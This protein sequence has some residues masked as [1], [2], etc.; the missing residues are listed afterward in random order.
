MTADIPDPAM[1]L[2]SGPLLSARLD[3]RLLRPGGYLGTLYVDGS[4]FGGSAV[5]GKRPSTALPLCLLPT[6][7]R[8]RIRMRG[9]R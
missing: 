2:C 7:A 9:S 5:C 3:R 1:R 8:M 6:V 4:A